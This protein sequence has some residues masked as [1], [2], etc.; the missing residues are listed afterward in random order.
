MG[1]K[2]VFP[3]HF[4][5]DNT[6]SVMGFICATVIKLYNTPAYGTSHWEGVHWKLA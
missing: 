3:G 2:A 1:L 4:F 6:D 5:P